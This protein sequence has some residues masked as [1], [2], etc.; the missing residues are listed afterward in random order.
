MFFSKNIIL[1]LTF[2]ALNHECLL[3]NYKEYRPYIFKNNLNFLI[4]FIFYCATIWLDL[5]AF[6]KSGTNSPIYLTLN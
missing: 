1:I 6:L 2:F 3:L 5:F 4:Y